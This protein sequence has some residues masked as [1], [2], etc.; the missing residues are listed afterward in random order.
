LPERQPTGDE[1]ENVLK[2]D[3]PYREAGFVAVGVMRVKTVPASG[4]IGGHWW[5]ARRRRV[6]DRAG[7]HRTQ[8][9]GKLSSVVGRCEQLAL[10]SDPHHL[11]VAWSGGRSI[12]L[13]DR[14]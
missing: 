12:D 2:E 11:V 7:Y 5:S 14:E 10:D 3:A 9:I 1:R 6:S 13:A 8:S 4:A